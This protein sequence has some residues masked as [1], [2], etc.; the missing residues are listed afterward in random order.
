VDP[1]KAKLDNARYMEREANEL[2]SEAQRQQVVVDDQVE[3]T[4]EL[5]VRA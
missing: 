2:Y 5:G 4:T 1:S 3:L